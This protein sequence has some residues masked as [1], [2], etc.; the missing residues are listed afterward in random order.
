MLALANTISHNCLL[1][2]MTVVSSNQMLQLGQGVCLLKELRSTWLPSA[3]TYL[4]EKTVPWLPWPVRCLCAMAPVAGEP[5]LCHGPRGRRTVSYRRPWLG[6]LYA[7]SRSSGLGLLH[8]RISM[9]WLVGRTQ[10]A[11]LAPASVFPV[12]R[13]DNPSLELNQPVHW[14]QPQ[15]EAGKLNTQK[16]AKQNRTEHPHEMK[17]CGAY[18]AGIETSAS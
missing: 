6:R 2:R 12:A 1:L 3:R 8:I 13:R 17:L 18:A 10:R 15:T 14:L 16:R 11:D 7:P 4:E 9:F 5:S